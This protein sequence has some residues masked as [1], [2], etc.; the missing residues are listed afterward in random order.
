MRCHNCQKL[1]HYAKECWAGEGAKNKPNNCAHLTQDE[2]TNSDSKDVL[3]MA[4][5]SSKAQPRIPIEEEELIAALVFNKASVDPTLNLEGELIHSALTAEAEPE[6]V[7]FDKAVIEEK[8]LKA[9]KEE[10]NSIEKN[11]TWELVKV[12]LKGEVVKHKAKLVS[13]EFLQK[14]GIDY[15]EVYASVARIEIIRL[16]VAIAT[17]ANWST[18]Q[19]DVKSAFLNGP[20]EKEVCVNQL[21]DF[22]VKGKENKVYKLK[23]ALYGLKQA[24]RAWNMRIDGYLS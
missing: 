14:V 15:G 8:W 17:N 3:L 19:L 5:I 13:K 1:G 16:V 23:K 10:I 6:P 21:H 24:P 20:L 22:V 7:E 9:M 2:G 4:I 12:N 18:H 11:Q